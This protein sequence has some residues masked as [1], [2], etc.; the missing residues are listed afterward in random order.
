MKYLSDRE[1][2]PR[3]IILLTSAVVYD[4]IMVY[5]LGGICMLKKEITNDDIHSASCLHIRCLDGF[6]SIA[7]VAWGGAEEHGGVPGSV[8]A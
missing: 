1:K 6:L 5:K 4:I 3:R 7:E 2:N 8:H